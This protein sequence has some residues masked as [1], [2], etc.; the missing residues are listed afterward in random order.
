M[1][2]DGAEPL[3]ATYHIR[4]DPSSVELA[5]IDPDG[6]QAMADTGAILP[7]RRDT[8]FLPSSSILPSAEI[9]RRWMEDSP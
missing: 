3:A 4:T 1:E 5:R 9:R 2:D 6:D 8:E 7:A